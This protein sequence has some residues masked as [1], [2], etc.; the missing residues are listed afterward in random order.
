MLLILQL[1][2]SNLIML[3]VCDLKMVFIYILYMT[4]FFLGAPVCFCFLTHVR[5]RCV[6]GG[7]LGDWRVG[8]VGQTDP[9]L[10]GMR[11]KVSL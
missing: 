7:V 3:C 8:A 4:S 9:C 1:L 10:R 6:C 2:S 11:D 5:T